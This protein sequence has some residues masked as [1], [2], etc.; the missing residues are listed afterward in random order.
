VIPTRILPDGR[1]AEIPPSECP[2]GHRLGPRRVLVGW[3]PDIEK[4][5]GAGW[6][7]FT[8]VECSS[9]IRYRSDDA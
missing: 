4:G 5:Y 3:T 6:R 9:V 8:C 1:L 7:T 2:N